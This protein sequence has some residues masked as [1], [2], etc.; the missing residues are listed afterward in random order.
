MNQHDLP[1]PDYDALPF[2]SIESRVRTLDAE[3]VERVLA[4]EREHADRIQVVMTLEH[5]LEALRSGDAEP[6]GGDPSAATPE[7]VPGQP[8]GSAASPATEGPTQNPPSQGVPSNPAQP[9]S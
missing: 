9:R 6:S 7:V 8:G 1:L 5:R 4:Y 3:G 2:G